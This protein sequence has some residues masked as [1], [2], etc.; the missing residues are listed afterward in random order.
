MLQGGLPNLVYGGLPDFLQGGLPDAANGGQMLHGGTPQC[1]PG[2]EGRQQSYITIVQKLLNYRPDT[3]PVPSRLNCPFYYQPDESARFAVS[4]VVKELSENAAWDFEISK[5][6]MFGILV[7]ETADG[8]KGYLKAYSGQILGR[9]DWEGWVPPVFDYLQPDGW[10]LTNGQ[11]I[12]SLNK[13]IEAAETSPRYAIA[14]ARLQ[15][16]RA[17]RD[18]AV[19]AYKAFMAREKETRALRRQSGE[20]VDI[21]IKESQYQ[22]ATLRR[23]KK[24]HEAA[25]HSAESAVQQHTAC[26]NEMRAR[27]RRLSDELQRWLFSRFVVTNGLAET[28]SLLDIFAPT[29]QHVPPSGAG[30]CCA[31]KLLQYAI[32]HR[33][34][35]CSMAEFWWGES[36]KGELRRHL[37]FYPACQ[38]KCKPILDFMLQGVATAANPLE[39]AEQTTSLHILYEDSGIIAVHK[40]EGMLSVPGTGKRLSAADILTVQLSHS[41]VSTALQKHKVCAPPHREAQTDTDTAASSPPLLYPTHRLDMQT[42]GVLVFAKSKAMQST[43]QRMFA[44]HEIR[45]RYVAV[46]ERDGDSRRPLHTGDEGEIRLPLSADYLNRPRQKVDYDGGKESVTRYVVR[47]VCATTARLDLFPLTGRTHQLRIHC[48]HPDGLGMPIVGD[49][50]YGTHSAR[51]LLHAESISFTHPETKK[52]ITIFDK[53][54]F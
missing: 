44:S 10:F 54:P 22:K 15:R 6:K 49:D 7:V 53:C 8:R 42:S 48:A 18:D 45:K 51:L 13:E 12:T 24:Q 2:Q 14:C 32:T 4:E 41:D 39:D 23:L 46:V 25:I 52:M 31:P 19:S 35:P 28:R 20:D 29:A 36:P 9:E 38:G 17:E 27:R 33:L 47:E 43:L 40:P 37:S 21:L 5:G 1:R 30:E 3:S 34:R 11:V 16:L 50:L 26:I